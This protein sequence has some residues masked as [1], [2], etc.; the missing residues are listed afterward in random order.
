MGFWSSKASPYHFRLQSL[1][2]LKSL[3]IFASGVNAS[4]HAFYLLYNSWQRRFL[5]IL[6]VLPWFCNIHSLMI[7]QYVLAILRFIYFDCWWIVMNND[8][9][10]VQGQRIASLFYLRISCHA[11]RRLPAVYDA[12]WIILQVLAANSVPRERRKRVIQALLLLRFVISHVYSFIDVY[13][14]SVWD[15]TDARNMLCYNL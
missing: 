4:L 8:G 7:A 6:Y 14:W 3:K 2:N 1:T 10:I 11:W 13:E 12:A 15:T 9:N 5:I